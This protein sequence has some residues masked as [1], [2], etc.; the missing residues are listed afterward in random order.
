M[1]E[2]STHKRNQKMTKYVPIQLSEKETLILLESLKKQKTTVIFKLMKL[3]KIK[4][5]KELDIE[6][7]NLTQRL[8]NLANEFEYFEY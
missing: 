7:D 6:I 3:F 4:K 1:E 5:I 8:Y 2:L